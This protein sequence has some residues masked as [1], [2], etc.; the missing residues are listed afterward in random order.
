MVNVVVLV[1]LASGNW[2][3]RLHS[4]QRSSEQEVILLFYNIIGV[5]IFLHLSVSSGK[6]STVL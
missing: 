1:A 2:G 4:L 5:E 6:V 3:C